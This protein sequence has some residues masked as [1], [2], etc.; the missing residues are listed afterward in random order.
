M[1]VGRRRRDEVTGTGAPTAR[2]EDFYPADE[3]KADLR[4]GR[5]DGRRRIP[6]YTQI[7]DRIQ[8]DGWFT[9]AYSEELQERGRTRVQ[10]ELHAYKRQVAPKRHLLAGM[11]ER[12]AA[13]VEEAGRTQEALDL[14][15]TELTPEELVPRNA[16]EEQRGPAFIH[17]RRRLMRNREAQRARD[18]LTALSGEADD[19]RQR[20]AELREEMDQDFE[21]AK[22]RARLHAANTELRVATYWRALTETHPEGRQLAVVL[23][24]VHQTLPSWLDEPAPDVSDDDVPDDTGDDEDRPSRRAAG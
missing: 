13:T 6:S 10:A 5:L 16:Q 8:T 15:A 2:V 9:T 17:R 14:T 3:N 24:C 21:R 22:V 23:P 11:R 4:R 7:S 19:I 12:L 20:I 1:I 18:R